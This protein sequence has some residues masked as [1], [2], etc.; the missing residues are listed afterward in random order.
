MKNKY[1]FLI[2]F[3]IIFSFNFVL[4]NK[5]TQ[6]ISG[7]SSL[8]QIKILNE[9]NK[10][11][12]VPV[13][14][15][16]SSAEKIDNLISSLSE[17][18]FKNVKKET[19]TI[20]SV[21]VTKAGLDNLANNSNV[22]WIDLEESLSP[23]L[24][25]SVPLINATQ[26]WA[27]DYT[28]KGQ[29]VCVIDTGVNASHPDLQG[30]IIGEK[31]YCRNPEGANQH[32]C[33]GGLNESNDA[34]DYNGHGTHVTGIIVS[35]D[36]TYRG[37]APN[38]SV[39]MVKVCNSSINNSCDNDDILLG[40][41]WC[42]D[43]KT[44]YNISV[45]S[46]SISDGGVYAPGNCYRIWAD[47]AITNAVSTGIFVDVASGNEGSTT[48]IGYPSCSPNAVSVGASTKNDGMAYFTNRASNLDLL[49]PGL[50][51][52]SLRWNG[53]GNLGDCVEVD[54]IMMCS[55]TSQA[56][57]H[58]AGVVALLKERDPTLSPNN[59]T[60]ILKN[61]N[62]SIY[63]SGTGLKFP[64]IDALKAINSLCICTNW[65]AHD[66][67]GPTGHN[68]STTGFRYST[69]TCNPAACEA[70]SKCEY[71][72]SCITGGGGKEITVCASGC[73]YTTIQNAINHSNA[74]DVVY[75]TDNRTYNEQI[76]MNF[77]T[78][79]RLQ[80]LSNA[81]IQGS[82]TGIGI[83]I[84]SKDAFSIS[85]CRINS[86]SYG[87]RIWNTD[88]G[89][90]ENTIVSNNG[91][92]IL[93]ENQ[94][95]NYQLTNVIVTGTINKG[96]RM[97]TEILDSSHIAHIY[98][99][100]S[101]I[102][103]NGYVGIFE[104]MGMDNHY[105]NN[106]ISG[107]SNY[108][109]QIYTN[110]LNANDYILNNKLFNNGKGIYLEYSN[111][112]TIND[113]NFCP[114]NTN[115]DI[116]IGYSTSISGDD[117]T[118]EKPGSWNDAGTTGC[119]FYCDSGA[120]VIL[121]FPPNNYE[122][123][124]G[125]ISLTCEA[126]DNY[127]IVNVSL[128]HNISGNWQINQ[129]RNISGTSNIT[130]FNVNN[131]INGT[132]FIW[133]CL[134]YDNNSRGGFASANW[135][136]SIVIDNIPPNVNIISPLNQ[137]YNISSINFNVTINEDGACEYSLNN[138]V[139]NISMGTIDNRNFTDTSSISNGNYLVHFY[140]MDVFG[141]LNYTEHVSFNV[142]APIPPND[143]HKFYIKNSTGSSVAWL[144]SFGNIVLKGNCF[145]GGSCS[146]PGDNSFIV[147]NVSNTNIAFINS[148]GDLCIVKG[149]CS[150]E[151]ATCNP[152]RDAFIIRN[153][154]NYNMSYIDFDGGLCLTGKLYETSSYV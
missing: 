17:I 2:L 105:L 37:V 117:N 142:N 6:E 109:I 49:A 35:Q 136:V 150:D 44:M 9:F 87:I 102:S 141:N 28:G 15:E 58:V 65:T 137:T 81:I 115:Q 72:S 149:D 26:V 39:V 100:D 123:S 101:N 14:V 96:I 45:I 88:N 30:K 151:S 86:F 130:T 145:S 114:S 75:V 143:T 11:D 3:L 119:T 84:T 24:S 64:R 83:N 92:G 4:A 34:E 52:W 110:D 90:I 93:I 91:Y 71:D 25:E 63:D 53:N 66:C 22:K 122:D 153:S 107:H 152:T 94:S 8:R 104:S 113:N 13:I 108:G 131:L 33:P 29:T 68:C 73:N 103:N 111:I 98:I 55:G 154:S 125:N 36:A 32:C 40:I 106:N 135:S 139:T 80:C 116:D 27:K 78:A 10:T 99:Q 74:V 134:A 76:K 62:V 144:G 70:E 133:N 16:V 61:N 21:K 121:L 56:A 7:F 146:N 77:T 42:K 23:V 97:E 118:C 18:N 127:Q 59:I 12:L 132:N 89:I 85:G 46:I 43:H 112:N 51:I 147:R 50:G 82:G 41:N 20:F 67:G 128:Y 54:D 48:G 47:S 31:C 148:T 5:I 60:T 69:K 124:Y 138:G 79:S 140:C 129:T 95:K 19:S 38:A 1:I 120:S 57:P 126:D